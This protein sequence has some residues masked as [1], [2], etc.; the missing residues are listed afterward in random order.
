MTS[1]ISQGR[2]QFPVSAILIACLFSLL[3]GLTHAVPG[4]LDRYHRPLERVL[5]SYVRQEKHFN[6]R[7]DY[8]RSAVKYR[9]LRNYGPWKDYID[10]LASSVPR[11]KMLNASDADKKAFWVNCYNAFVIDSVMSNYPVRGAARGGFP[12]HSIQSIPDFWSGK[13]CAAQTTL[14]LEQIEG[15]L[16]DL[17]DIRVLFALNQGAID[18]PALAEQPY[19]AS[20]IDRILDDAVDNYLADPLNYLLNRET[21]QLALSGY[22]KQNVSKFWSMNP[23]I[24]PAIADYPTDQRPVL[25]FILKHV[26]QEDKDYIL[27]KHP[28]ITFTEF[29]WRLNEAR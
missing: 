15:R 23:T 26:R 16:M 5:K 24:P 9:Q 12:Q 3:P 20:S 27:D 21:N 6:G 22:F 18:S 2:N 25:A 19:D 10:E 13:H 29:N 17:D 28:T 4:P 11:S 1:T 14:S 7:R 8:N